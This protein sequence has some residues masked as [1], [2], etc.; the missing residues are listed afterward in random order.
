MDF[1]AM[2][3]QLLGVLANLV[4]NWGVAIII[5]TLVIRALLWPSSVT[6]QRSMRQM[7][8]LQPKMKQIQERYKSNPEQ[9]Q[10]KMQEF[11]KEHKFN[12]FSG[13][14]PLILQLPVFILLYSALISPQFIEAA[15]NANFLFIKRLDATIKSDSGVSYDGNF[16]LDN[17]A[18]FTSDKVA[19]VYLKGEK[20]PL[21]GVKVKQPLKAVETQGEIVASEPVDLKVALDSLDLKFDQLNK[22]QKA[23]FVIINTGTKE[24]ENVTFE[25]KGDILAASVPTTKVVASMHYDVIFLVL[26]FVL[27]MWLSQKVMMS[28]SKNAPQDSTT[29]AMQKSMGTMM[30]IMIGATFIFIPIPAGVLLYLVTSNLF[31]I[32]QTIVVNKQLDKEEQGKHGANPKIEVEAI[33]DKGDKIES[34]VESTSKE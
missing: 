3:I 30:P 6:Q 20:E 11:Y 12:P 22:I 17:H 32:V 28:S 10:K 8:F 33:D 19:V 31:Q 9:M 18:K 16:S 25:R 7:Q 24:I 4:G 26:L 15:G 13:C 5:L 34:V 23:D 29:A 2:T 14:L 27:T 21:A 1:T